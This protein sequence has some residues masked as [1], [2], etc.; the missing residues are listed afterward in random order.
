[1]RSNRI[2]APTPADVVEEASA[3]AIGGGI[4][5]FVLFPFILPI[6]LLTAAFVIPFLLAGLAI[7]L[8]VGLAAAPILLL[9]HLRRRSAVSRRSTSASRFGLRPVRR[10]G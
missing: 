6:L 1:M 10:A 8:V 7:A 3:W 4:I 9:R 2:N 5:T